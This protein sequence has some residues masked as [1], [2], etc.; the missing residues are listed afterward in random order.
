[1]FCGAWFWGIISDRYGRKKAYI[2]SLAMLSIF[3]VS[4]A[5]SPNLTVLLIL[6]CAV[7]IGLGGVPVAVALYTEFLPRKNRGRYLTIMQS[8]WAVAA[9]LE[10]LLAWAIMPTTGLGT[11]KSWQVFVLVSVLPA[12]VLLLVTMIPCETCFFPESPRY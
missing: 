5:F 11:L 3:G 12:I 2:G 8:S 4:S 7:G 9:V 1:M 10:V 6:R